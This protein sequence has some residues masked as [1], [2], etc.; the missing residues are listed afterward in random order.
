MT[1]LSTKRILILTAN[2]T[3]T[4]K[5]QLDQEAGQL[6]D[7]LDRAKLRDRFELLPTRRN[8]TYRDLQ[9][10][11]LNQEPHII[12]FSGH[13]EGTDGICLR[14]EVGKTHLVSG[15]A[16]AGL[17]EVC[18]QVECVI[19]NACYSE[20]QAK[21][22]AR[23]VP[24]VI[25]MNDEIS[26]PAAI[27][28]TFGFYTA[29]GAGK[30][31]EA[32][33]K[34]GCNSIW[35]YSEAKQQDKIPV[36]IKRE[37]LETVPQLW[38]HGWVKQ[39]F[40][41]ES[42]EELNWTDYFSKEPYRIPDQAIWQQV[43]LPQLRQ[44]RDRWAGMYPKKKIILRGR[45]PLTAMVAI[46]AMFPAAAGYRFEVEQFTVG[47]SH[48]W[49]SD[50]STSNLRFR[51][52]EMG[53]AGDDVLL[54]L[55]IT[56]GAKQDIRQMVQEVPGQFSA[57]VYA[58]PET[59]VGDRAITNADA[60]ALAEH[61]KELIRHIRQTYGAK[62]IHLAP[63]TPAAFCLFLGQHLNAVGEIVTYEFDPQTGYQRSVVLVG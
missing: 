33:Y 63:Y 36:L 3:D 49:R 41:E 52:T 10:H 26:D 17:L 4:A 9:Q 53:K 55:A 35:R 32:A 34:V 29:L 18:E 23:Y 58:E 1:D 42:T 47:T 2:P 56:S 30:S 6:T 21:A 27:E 5:L 51:V 11:I 15:E 13:G 22:I 43:L 25:G 31:Y 61:S 54:A 39:R 60:I 38:I 59:G 50:E 28:F 7:I 48:Q 46:G 62:R 45:L 14:D 8:V 37:S 19:L 20:I 57:I 44:I 16:F 12:H 40:E 24:Y